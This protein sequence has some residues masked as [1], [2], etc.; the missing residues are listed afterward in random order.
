MQTRRPTRLTLE[1]S[2]H[3]RSDPSQEALAFGTRRDGSTMSTTKTCRRVRSFPLS[4]IQRWKL[5]P[6]G[7]RRNMVMDLWSQ[8]AWC[9]FLKKS[10]GSEMSRRR[11]RQKSQLSPRSLER[12]L[13]LRRKERKSSRRAAATRLLVCRARVPGRILFHLG[14]ARTQDA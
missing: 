7:S 11:P 10:E 6:S 2:R 1:V 9:C 3:R 5:D 8:F 12:D 14:S 13:R 4:G